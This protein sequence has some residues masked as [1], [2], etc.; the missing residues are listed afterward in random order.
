[1]RGRLLGLTVTGIPETVQRMNEWCNSQWYSTGKRGPDP[2][3][4]V[5]AQTFSIFLQH[6]PENVRWLWEQLQAGVEFQELGQ[7]LRSGDAIAGSDGSYKDGMG[8]SSWR[9]L[10]KHDETKIRAGANFVPGRAQ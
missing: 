8:T 7:W 3:K 4:E 1:M 2:R 9:I 6:Q 5:H 10:S